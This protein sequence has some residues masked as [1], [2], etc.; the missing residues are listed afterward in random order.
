MNDW[1]KFLFYTGKFS[2][3]HNGKIELFIISPHIDF[4]ALILS[5][6]ILHTKFIS[7]NQEHIL[8]YENHKGEN[9]VFPSKKDDEIIFYT[10]VLQRIDQKQLFFVVSDTLVEYKTSLG[11]GKNW[12]KKTI[13]TDHARH[14]KVVQEKDF[15]YVYK[16]GEQTDLNVLQSGV[17]L[18]SVAYYFFGSGST[19]LNSADTKSC[20]IVDQKKRLVDELDS[21][22]NLKRVDP[23]L[24]KT[25]RIAEIIYP[26]NIKHNSKC[27]HS[28][29]TR[30]ISEANGVYEYSDFKSA[31]LI[32]SN[33]YLKYG[34][35]LDNEKIIT[36][37]SPEDR[38]FDDAIEKANTSFESRYDDVLLPSQLIN[39]LP[40][41]FDIQAWS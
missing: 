37:V 27:S 3:N 32:G 31:I 16:I 13:Q 29:V 34:G 5:I 19:V 8:D 41:S 12:K 39:K 25:V 2:L 21:E 26:Y 15:R 18:D 1:I 14:I 30:S 20:L 17:N 40:L 35:N 11:R 38:S 7:I 9:F 22:I 6:G 28:F 23:N 4:C 10:G 33:N 36:I 24:N